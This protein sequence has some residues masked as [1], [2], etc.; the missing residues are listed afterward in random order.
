MTDK[1]EERIKK[2]IENPNLTDWEKGI[3]FFYQF[4]YG[5]AQPHF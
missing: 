2:L 5:K 1:R 4:L 3:S